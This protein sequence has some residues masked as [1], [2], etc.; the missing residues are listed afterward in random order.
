MATIDKK[1]W[2]NKGKKASTRWRV[3]FLDDA[4]ARK[5][6]L[7]D[8]KSDAVRFSESVSVVRH[9]D[10]SSSAKKHGGLTFA[11]VAEAYLDACERGREGGA[12]LEPV[13]VRAYREEINRRILPIVGSRPITSISRNDVKAVRDA[14]M[15]S[16]TRTSARRQLFLFKAVLNYA[17]DEG[18][19]GHAPTERV[20][21]KVDRR[22]AA[23]TKLMVHT[24]EEMSA[25]LTAAK[26]L[27]CSTGRYAS[28]GMRWKRLETMLHVLV[29][30]GLRMSEL[31]GLPV[32]AINLDKGTLRVIQ[33]ADRDGVVGPPK[34]ASAYRTVQMPDSLQAL[35]RGWEG[36][37]D[38]LFPTATS[39]PMCHNN[40]SKN[41]WRR[42]QEKAGVTILNPH[43]TRHFFAS[44]LIR[45][46]ANVKVIQEAMGHSDPMFTMRVYGHLFVDEESIALRKSMAARMS[47][48]LVEA[49][50]D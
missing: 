5:E 44:M 28:T 40:L 27:R 24:P 48:T 50:E 49:E 16:V 12:P 30:T 20:T 21:V 14:L 34:S 38:L 45:Q 13:T 39:K 35:L 17:V 9:K 47:A 10:L 23:S 26:E 18:M 41:L 3:R 2:E 43:S 29:F 25:I 32:S 19:I 33:R 8:T 22:R 6:R 1:V 46:G 37:G 31:R 36:G 42:V 11:Q 7:F 4:G 15:L